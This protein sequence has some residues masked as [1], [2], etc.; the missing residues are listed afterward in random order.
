MSE[1]FC[2]IGLAVPY[3]VRTAGP[4]KHSVYKEEILKGAFKPTTLSARYADLCEFT[5]NHDRS[6][7]VAD[8][9]VR[10]V[11]K[12]RGLY[13]TVS[14]PKNSTARSILAERAAWRGVSISFDASTAARELDLNALVSRVTYIDFISG[15]SVTTGATR[16][17]YAG[18]WIAEHSPAAVARVKSEEH[19]HLVQFW[20]SDYKRL[21]LSWWCA[22]LQAP[23]IEARLATMEPDRAFLVRHGELPA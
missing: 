9:Q 19:Q 22:P 23:E 21:P 7:V 4:V 15:V 17:A 5:A 16:P 8:A 11:N 14:M 10:F 3:G 12:H 18:T 6:R 13:F 1:Q 2:L 20:G